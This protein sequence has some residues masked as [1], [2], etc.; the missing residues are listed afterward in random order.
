[1]GLEKFDPSLASHDLVQDLK[2]DPTLRRRFSLS[3]K[4]VNDVYPVFCHVRAVSFRRRPPT[5]TV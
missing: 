3:A 4:G 2:W 1:M 5:K